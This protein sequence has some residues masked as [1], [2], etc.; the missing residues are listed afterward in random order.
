M[1]ILK[2]LALLALAVF[3]FEGGV[4]AVSTSTS[5]VDW[6]TERNTFIERSSSSIGWTEAEK[7]E[8]HEKK[9]VPTRIIETL[10]PEQI[11]NLIRELP[12]AYAAYTS[13]TAR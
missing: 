1:K 2:K 11:T 10:T 5:S 12:H 3:A 8:Y 4:F 6:E 9:L 13:Q 7:A